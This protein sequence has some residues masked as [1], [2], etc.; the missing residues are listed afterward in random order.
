MG[1][2]A[3][4]F[5]MTKEVTVILPESLAYR[6]SAVYA[7]CPSSYDTIPAPESA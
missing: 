2:S 5:L 3:S 7:L 1:R 6:K 4:Y